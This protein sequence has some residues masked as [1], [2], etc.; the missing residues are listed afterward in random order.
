METWRTN[1]DLFRQQMCGMTRNVMRLVRARRM[2]FVARPKP[3]GTKR[4]DVVTDVDVAAQ[5]FFAEHLVREFPGVGIIGEEDLRVPCTL[6][7]RSVYWTVD[8]LDGSVAFSEYAPHGFGVMLALV[9]EGEVVA[10][11]IGDAMTGTVYW[12]APGTPPVWEDPGGEPR[13]ITGFRSERDEPSLLFGLEPDALPWE[14]RQLYRQNAPFARYDLDRGSVGLR[15]ARL[16]MGNVAG[17]V[18]RGGRKQS[19]WDDTPLIGFCRQLGFRFLELRDGLFVPMDPQPA[20]VT[21]ET[22][23][24]HP[25]LVVHESRVDQILRFVP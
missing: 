2:T 6:P 7:G 13:P 8:P 22:P 11:C 25:V 23:S 18:L 1:P 24:P 12:F 5:A 4:R 16:F 9:E 21:K 3:S 14:L 20:P 17:N 19:P 15:F 10:S